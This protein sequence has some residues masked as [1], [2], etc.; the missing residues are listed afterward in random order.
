MWFVDMIR[1]QVLPGQS[2]LAIPEKFLATIE[3]ESCIVLSVSRWSGGCSSRARVCENRVE[4][5]RSA[6]KADNVVVTVA[7]IRKGASRMRFQEVSP[8]VAERNNSFWRD[9]RKDPSDGH[10]ALE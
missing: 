3:D 9:L 7:G 10:L 8:E 6:T 1:A 2:S 5:A 4:F